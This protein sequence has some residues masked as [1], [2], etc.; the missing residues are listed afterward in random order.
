MVFRSP[1]KILAIKLRAMGDTILMTAPLAELR[2]A[3]PEAEIHVMAQTAWAPLL[4]GHPAVD[5]LIPFDRKP[6]AAAR[7]KAVARMALDLR[8]AKYDAVV[9]FHASP[10]SATLSFATGARIRSIHFHGH[11]DKNRYSTVEVPGKGV[12]KPII[13]RDMDTVRALGLHVDEGKLPEIQVTA[14][15]RT[16]ARERIDKLV[17]AGPLLILGLGSSRPSKNWGLD[18]F[19]GLAIQWVK[20]TGGAALALAGP[21][22]DLLVKTFLNEIDQQLLHIESDRD[23]ASLKARIG[24]DSGVPIQILPAYIREAAVF[25]GNDS[26]PKHLAVAVGTPTATV[27][28]PEHPFEWH[29]YPQDRHPYFFIEGL[30]CRRDADPGMKPW[31]AINVCIEQQHRCMRGIGISSVLDACLGLL[32][33]GASR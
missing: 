9:N 1:R 11:R 22:E 15:A 29:P 2:A 19:A 31:C 4:E 5:R 10:S 14:D 3:Y 8:K 12:L 13:E 30:D 21:G 33:K 18:R 23:R 32:K 16:R 17:P 6:S 20:A 25:A 7:T 27:F 26:G 28:G 24:C